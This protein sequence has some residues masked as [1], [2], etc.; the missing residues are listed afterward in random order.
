MKFRKMVAAIM[1]VS[2]A[3]TM[4]PTVALAEEIAEVVT[5]VTNEVAETA[6]AKVGETTYESLEE[7][8]AAAEEDATVTLLKSTEGPGVVIDKD[9]TIDFGGKTY[10]F[11]TP[12]VGSTGTTTN[13]F[14]IL[15]GNDVTLMDGALEVADANKGE[16]YILIQNY[17]D[18]TVTDMKLDGENL[19]RQSLTDGDSYVLSNNCGTVSIEDTTI[20]ANDDGDL[21]FAFDA[22]KFSSYDAPVVTVDD[23]CKVYGGIEVSPEATLVIEGGSFT[24]LANAV[25]YTKDNATIKLLESVEGPGIVIDKDITIDFNKK[26]YDIVGPAVGSAGTTTLGFQ[27]LKNNDV[28]LEN[29]T[30]TESTDGALEQPKAVKM[31]VQNYAN[32]TLDKNFPN[33]ELHKTYHLA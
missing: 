23:G 22:C 18:L 10:T 13:G 4:M 7:A 26:T 24:D 12:A 32:L 8:I 5:E 29:G 9:I 15:E 17:A 14:Q 31:L 19:D 21:A 1:T 30:I 11:T 2:M 3:A 20:V 27:I 28:T 16:Y 6:V 25:K 33:L